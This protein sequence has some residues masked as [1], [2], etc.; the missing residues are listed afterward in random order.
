MATLRTLLER[1]IN[2]ENLPARLP[3]DGVKVHFSY[4]NTKW[5][6]P[7]NTAQTYDDLGADYETDTCCRDHDH[8]DINVSQGNVVCGVVNPGLFSM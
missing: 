7:G 3:L 5:C 6:G 1:F 4:P 2:N 8:C